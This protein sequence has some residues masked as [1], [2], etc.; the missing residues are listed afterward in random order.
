MASLRSQKRQAFSLLELL[1]VIAIIAILIA[2]LLLGFQKVREAAA[3]LACMNN[4]S[5]LGYAFHHYH[6]LKGEFPTEGG[7]NPSFYKTLLPYV[8]G[9]N[10]SDNTPISMYLCPTRRNNE[11]GAKRD[12]GYAAS[13]GSAT[14][15]PS[16]LDADPI[17][18]S[19]DIIMSHD[20]ATNK[21]LLTHLWMSPSTYRGGD[22]TD[23]G[24][25][26]KNNSRQND[27]QTKPDND[28]TG[29]SSY[30]GGPHPCGVPTL[31]ADG[32][33]SNVPYSNIDW[34]DY[35]AYQLDSSQLGAAGGRWVRIWHDGSNGGGTPGGSSGSTGSG[36]PTNTTNNYTSTTSGFTPSNN[37]QN[38][39][40]SVNSTDYQNNTSYQQQTNT[41]Q[42]T[43]PGSQTQ[44]LS[45][46]Q[47]AQQTPDS[48]SSR[49]DQMKQSLQSLVQQANQYAQ[50]A[51]N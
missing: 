42:N 13:N 35:W 10:A 39:S 36:S 24:W 11:V 12:Y 31:W 38:L 33:V 2:L 23:Q 8:E 44:S 18:A 29:D 28:P 46:R 50:N 17:P 45:S 30:L 37:V 48:P 6:H 4:M 22:P 5:N 41:Y 25:A 40:N 34:P 9:Q 15:G 47:S 21:S 49:S 3:R 26:T 43:T 51:M 19:L 20:G 27:Y 1:V 14:K 16:V 32:H 7:S